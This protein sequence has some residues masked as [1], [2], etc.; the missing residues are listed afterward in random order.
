MRHTFSTP[1]LVLMMLCLIMP[2]ILASTLR[3]S[4]QGHHHSGGG[5]DHWLPHLE[6]DERA[7]WQM[8]DHVIELMQMKPGM[9]AADIGAGTGYFLERLARAAGPSGRVLALDVDRELVDFMSDRVAV[10]GWK[11]VEA[12][13]AQ[14]DNPGLEPRS[15][16]RILIVNTWH[17]IGN[18]E[19]YAERLLHALRPDG[20]ILVVEL[21]MHSPHG[22]PLDHRLQAEQVIQ[23]LEAGGLSARLLEERLPHQY[24]V[25][26]SRP[27]S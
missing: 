1:R 9:R 27:A 22:P 16:D 21:T 11:N 18:R 12:R 23:E 7:S 13:L 14:P 6:G 4:D 24:A 8:P 17:H 5:V 19:L 20:R 25:E 26:A 15:V 10:E 3:A 2:I